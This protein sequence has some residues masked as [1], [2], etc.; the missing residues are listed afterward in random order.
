MHAQQIAGGLWTV[1]DNGYVLGRGLTRLEA[2]NSIPS[3]QAAR[4]WVDTGNGELAPKGVELVDPDDIPT[5]RRRI[6]EAVKDQIAASYPMVHGGLRMD[7]KDLEY[8]DPEDFGPEEQKDALLNNKTLARRLRG[9]MTL[10]DE[11]TGQKLDEK[12]LS[13]VRVPHLTER[14]TFI[15]AGNEHTSICQSRLAPGIY[16]RK[17]A[18]GVHETQFNVRP[19]TGRQF[20]TALEPDTGQFRLRVGANNLHLY[21]LFKDLGVKDEDLEKRWGPE[22]LNINR[23]KYDPKA[24]HKA[25]DRLVRPSQKAEHATFE[26][27]R[28]AVQAALNEAQVNDQI[29][30]RNLPNLFDFRKTAEWR[31]AEPPVFTPHFTPVEAR[32][33][34]WYHSGKA[35][36]EKEAA[37]RMSELQELAVF[38]SRTTGRYINTGGSREELETSIMQAM[39]GQDPGYNEAVMQAGVEAASQAHKAAREHDPL[40]SSEHEEWLDWYDGYHSGKRRFD[41]ESYIRGWA[42]KTASLSAVFAHDPT[43][44]TAME[45]K[46]WAFD[47]TRLVKNS[48]DRE[49]L[50]AGM[51]DLIKF[52]GGPNPGL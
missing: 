36:Q 16:T 48:D 10:A 34:H 7:V 51:L 46:G 33:G 42:A 31:D 35:R 18:N 43:P 14:G 23:N 8:E 37:F 5:R 1:T 26:E 25:Y 3:K 6:Y 27:K 9:T 39:S 29:A 47:A 13:L 20:R 41:D 17:Q 50:R 38:I 44:E 32:E 11:A 22:L 24:I 15:H 45:L 52:F 21:S 4:Q 12:R 40:G 19:G 49:D 2:E 30:R 28:D